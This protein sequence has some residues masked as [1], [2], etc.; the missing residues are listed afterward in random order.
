MHAVRSV[1]RPKLSL[2]VPTAASKPSVP[3]LVIPAGVSSSLRTATLPSPSP[4][5][6]T[7]RNTQANQ[8]ALSSSTLQIPSAR[9]AKKSAKKVSFA[10]SHRI[11]LISPCPQEYYGEYVKMSREERRWRC[12]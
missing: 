12:S 4:Q 8:R 3:Q 6:P 5:T 1:A 11:E 7:A 9:P 10:D 2:A